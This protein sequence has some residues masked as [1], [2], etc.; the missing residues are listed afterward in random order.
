ME[1]VGEMLDKRLSLSWIKEQTS[2]KVDKRRLRP[3]DVTLQ[4]PCIDKFKEATGWE[5]LIP[6][7]TTM[8][9]LLDYWRQKLA[10]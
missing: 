1:A 7:E 3:T 10:A 8:Q 4:I 9:D 2:I 5:P 6:F